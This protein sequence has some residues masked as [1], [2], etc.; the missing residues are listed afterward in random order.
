[1]IGTVMVSLSRRQVLIGGAAIFFVPAV[2]L[3]AP[4]KAV[5][6][7]RI[8]GVDGKPLAGVRFREALTDADGRFMLVTDTSA[9]PVS[10]AYRDADGTWR[11]TLSL[12]L[13]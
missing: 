1:M 7:G 4:E 13:A 3:A 5:L 2:S 9:F 11:A 8:T 6:S 10:S 12:R